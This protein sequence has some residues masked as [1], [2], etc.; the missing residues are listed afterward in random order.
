MVT[1]KGVP[2]MAVEGGTR[3]SWVA[4][5]A[6]TII[7]A[8][9]ETELVVVSWTVSVCVPA[10]KSVTPPKKVWLPWSLEVKV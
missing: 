1:L 10:V 6:S 3:E 8:V 5:E 4:A 9:P 2:A 7:V